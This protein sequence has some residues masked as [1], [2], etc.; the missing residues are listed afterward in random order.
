MYTP[1]KVTTDYSLLKS[2]IKVSDLINFCVAKNIQSCAICD[3]NLFGVIEFYKTCKSHNIK[4][5]VGLEITLNNYQIYL[6]AKNKIGYKNL[7][8]I[9]TIITERNVSIIELKNLSDILLVIIPYQSINIYE[10]LAFME[11]VYLGYEN[12]EELQN[13]LIKSQNVVYVNNIKAFKF[14]DGPYLKYLH[15]LEEIE[16]EDYH[17]YFD[18]DNL[19]EFDLAKIDEVERLLNLN[20]DDKERYTSK[21]MFQKP[22]LIV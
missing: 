17:F 15:L 4:P 18:Y 5:I 3:T 13:E 12:K 10:D 20:L 11:T 9:N 19:T 14:E 6:Y 7:L 16:K 2:L 22:I 21:E 8:K 1:L